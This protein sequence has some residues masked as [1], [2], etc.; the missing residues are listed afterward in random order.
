[1][2][3]S[4]NNSSFIPK[5]GTTKRTRKVRNV[6]IY[7]INIA[8]Y[9]LMFAALVAAAG[10]YFYSNYVKEQLLNETTAMSAAVSIVC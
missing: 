10:V 4:S 2:P 6:N 8:S 1:M 7:I 3:G 5:R 9:T